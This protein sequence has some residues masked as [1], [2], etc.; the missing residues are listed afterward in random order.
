[1][2]PAPAGTYDL[3]TH[4]AGD[5]RVYEHV[6]FSTNG[7]A[8]FAFAR[9]LADDPTDADEVAALAPLVL[10]DMEDAGGSSAGFRF[11]T[12]R[13]THYGRGEYTATAL[14]F[15]DAERI[16]TRRPREAW[17]HRGYDR[18]Q[19]FPTVAQVLRDHPDVRSAIVRTTGHMGYVRDG[20]GFGLSAR[21]R[22][23]Y[24]VVLARYS[25]TGDAPVERK[26]QAD[27]P[28]VER[29]RDRRRYNR[30]V[31]AALA[32]ETTDIYTILWR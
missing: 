13:G 22:C 26:R 14:G 28:A 23:D 9:A 32:R 15:A 25:D 30:K 16:E 6:P 1:M 31:R 12:S 5:G 11:D 4:R 21:M 27:T 20:V 10:D 2:T 24:I 18:N 17:S 3:D 7:C 19:R 8:V 29:R